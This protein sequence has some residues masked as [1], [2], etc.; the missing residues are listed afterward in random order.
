MALNYVVLTG[1]ITLVVGT[2]S[3]QD[4]ITVI[5]ATATAMGADQVQAIRYSGTGWLAAVGQGYTPGED[6]PRAD[7]T[8]TRTIDYESRASGEQLTR[9]QG[10][11]APRGGGGISNPECLKAS[12]SGMPRAGAAEFP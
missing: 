2:A 10:E 8:Y 4:A 9:R 3:A 7:L 11:Y 12:V 5:Q 1:L 6:W